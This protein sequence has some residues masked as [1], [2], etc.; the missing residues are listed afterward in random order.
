MTNI[1]ISVDSFVYLLRNILFDAIK[2]V[3]THDQNILR[4]TPELI[5]STIDSANIKQIF[6]NKIMSHLCSYF[7]YNLSGGGIG[8]LIF[9]IIKKATLN[10]TITSEESSYHL[11]I[12]D[13]WFEIP[14][15]DMTNTLIRQLKIKH[16]KKIQILIY[17][18][19]LVD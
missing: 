11:N 12:S 18:M 7:L 15:V 14:G 16:V 8:L 1:Q 9:D 5:D 17:I 19:L 10:S 4:L 3:L 6:I 13:I 2:E